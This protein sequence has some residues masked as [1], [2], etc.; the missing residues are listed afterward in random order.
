MTQKLL[1]STHRILSLGFSNDF[2]SCLA[3]EP[4]RPN[5]PAHLA[6]CSWALQW[7]HRLY[8]FRVAFGGPI[9]FV[10]GCIEFRVE[11]FQV[12]RAVVGSPRIN[13]TYNQKATKK[14]K[15]VLGVSSKMPAW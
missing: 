2:F 14:V 11:G 5:T 4:E 7:N 13:I 10:L 15:E 9:G 8:G 1:T 6:N 3:Y 12:S